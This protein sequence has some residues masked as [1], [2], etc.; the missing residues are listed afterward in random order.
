[1]FKFLVIMEYYAIYF[2]L[3]IVYFVE[4][5]YIK[6]LTLQIRILII[7]KIIITKFNFRNTSSSVLYA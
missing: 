2:Y 1:M 3:F 4:S 6:N 7:F 5:I